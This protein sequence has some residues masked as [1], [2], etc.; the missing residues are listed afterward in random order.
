MR[1]LARPIPGAGSRDHDGVRWMSSS[2]SFPGVPPGGRPAKQQLVSLEGYPLVMQTARYANNILCGVRVMLHGCRVRKVGIRQGRLELAQRRVSSQRH[3]AS[4][5]ARRRRCVRSASVC[6]AAGVLLLAGCSSAFSDASA[7][8]SIA[9]AQG[10]FPHGRDGG[11]GATQALTAGGLI[12]SL[13]SAGFDV[14]NPL[15]TTAQDCAASGCRQSITTDTL[16]VES[17]ATTAQADQYAAKRGLYQVETIVV[18][19]APPLPAAEQARYRSEIQ[20][21]VE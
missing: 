11:T 3:S 20:K 16:R 19:F 10:L 5:A 18:S 9:D 4:T 14:P 7:E 6:L 13:N 12:D 8:P 17:F 15:D 1:A 2:V 21:L